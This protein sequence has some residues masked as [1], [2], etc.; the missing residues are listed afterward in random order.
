MLTLS[1]R[2]HFICLLALFFVTALGLSAGETSTTFPLDQVHPGL[3]G[4]AYTIFTGDEVEKVDLVVLGVLHDA[5]GPKQ[6]VILVQ[7]LGEKAEHSGVV[8]GMSGSPVYFEGK[9]AGALSLKLGVFT[10]EAIGGVTPIENML[11]VNDAPVLPAVGARAA[12]DTGGLQYTARVPLPQN[13]AA[14]TGAGA[15]EFLVP[16]ET[17]LITT[18]VYPDTMAQ[19]SK[20]L[21]GWGMSMM[22]GG[23]APASPDDARLKPGDMVGVEL[24]RGDL[25]ITPGCTVTTV[26]ANGKVLACGHPIFSFGNVAMPMARAHV[27]TTLASAL[28][29]TKI[30]ST[31]GTIGTLTQDRMTAIG[32]QLGPEPPMIPITVELKTPTEERKFHF[33]AVESPQL[34]PTLVALATYNGI[35][36]STAYGEGFTL[37]LEGEIQI[38]GHTAVELNDLFAPSDIPV[39]TGFFAAGTVQAAFTKIYS[40]PYEV[41][42]VSDIHI[43]VTAIPERRSATIEN[44]WIEKNELTP[45][46]TVKVKVQL[47]PYRGASFIQEIPVTI[48]A[49]A[50]RGNLQLVISDAETVNRTVESAAASSQGQLS[51]LEEMIKLMNRDRENNRLY[52]TLLQPTA[53]LLVEDKIMPNAPT[54]EISVMDHRQTTGAVRVSNQSTAG[55]WSVEM[56]QVISGERTL[57]ITVR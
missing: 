19:F 53:T 30:I 8:A 28:A 10:K 45:G 54:S 18:G 3:K 56:H 32:G 12:A 17:P 13:F 42:H 6:D 44:A 34:T 11:S 40:N 36:G 7:L 20:E 51:G 46:E 4:V 21:A 16:I 38:Q 25:T 14:Q 49:Q 55:E 9:L 35:V 43:R 29:S 50:A 23:T 47:R 24:M 48:P 22:A 27:I 33:E 57:P 2:R 52:A 39:P 5:L 26:E 15:G 37:Q 41:P 1:L 31:G